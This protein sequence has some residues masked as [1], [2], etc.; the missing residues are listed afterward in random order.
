MDQVAGAAVFEVGRK[1]KTGAAVGQ[2]G[3]RRRRRPEV[4]KKLAQLALDAK[5]YRARFAGDGTPWTSTS[6]TRLFTGCL[7]KRWLREHDYKEAIDEFLATI[8]L[9]PKSLACGL[10]WPT[11]TC[12]PSSPSRRVQL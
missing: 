4:R 7:P 6:S 3:R 5:D 10:P 12:K 8:K 2:A 9:E 11:H 1:E